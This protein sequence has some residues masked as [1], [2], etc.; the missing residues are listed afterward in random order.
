MDYSLLDLETLLR[1]LGRFSVFFHHD[2]AA[3]GNFGDAGVG[4]PT[5]WDF[6]SELRLA[7][8]ADTEGDITFNPGGT[9]AEL[10]L[11]EISGEAVHEATYT[12]DNP[13]IETP[14]FLADPDLLP[15]CSPTGKASAGH[16]RVRD[17]DARTI[18]LFP[19]ELFKVSDDA[20]YATLAYSGGAFTLDGSPLSAA[21]QTLLS[22]AVWLW[23]C[24]P[25]RPTERFRGGHGND[26]KNIETVAWRGMMH[27]DA[28]NGERLWTRGNPYSKGIDLEGGS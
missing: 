28:P 3:D 27:P 21:K 15:V 5:R 24:Y 13:T 22:A 7:H 25:V 18:V 19:E 4:D 1:K 11:P 26:A 20:G 23:N 12:G 8:L 14:L 2:G 9:V 6:A 17:V 10:Q 16:F